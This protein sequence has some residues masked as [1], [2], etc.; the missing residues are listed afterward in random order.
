VLSR[1]R[2][3]RR[4]GRDGRPWSMGTTSGSNCRTRPWHPFRSSSCPPWLT[5]PRWGPPWAPSTTFRRRLH[6]TNCSRSSPATARDQ[7]SLLSYRQAGSTD[8]ISACPWEQSGCTPPVNAGSPLRSRAEGD[9]GSNRLSAEMAKWIGRE[10]E[11]VLGAPLGTPCREAVSAEHGA[12]KATRTLPG[13][14]LAR[15]HAGGPS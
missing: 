12:P 11:H 8:R 6:P 5:S 13:D 9:G 1:A 2:Q 14:R 15:L 10:H 7:S 4:F 3:P